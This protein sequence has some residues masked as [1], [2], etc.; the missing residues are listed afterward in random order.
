[1]SIKD[2][3]SSLF[4]KKEDGNIKAKTQRRHIGDIGED[5]ACEYLISLGYSIVGRNIQISHKE[6]DIVAEDDYTTVIVEVKTLSHTKEYAESCAHRASE[7]IDREK[8][9]NILC[10]AQIY[11]KAHYNGKE[12]RIDVIEVYLGGSSPEIVHTENAI[13][14]LMLNRRR[15]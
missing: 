10:A 6:I 4:L 7:Q 12:T 15:R 14:K 11:T 8:A 1:M 9:Q 3:L 2:K 5:I 13:N